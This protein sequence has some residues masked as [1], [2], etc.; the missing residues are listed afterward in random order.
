MLNRPLEFKSA[1]VFASPTKGKQPSE[2]ERVV[3]GCHLR[4]AMRHV[5]S[6]LSLN[7]TKHI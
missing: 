4:S 6:V 1:T 3:S 7:V 2:L 5:Y